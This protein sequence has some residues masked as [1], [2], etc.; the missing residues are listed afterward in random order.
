MRRKLTP[1]PS[2]SRKLIVS[3]QGTTVD[4]SPSRM[5]HKMEVTEEKYS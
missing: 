3:F 5:E 2:S 4:Q 1:P